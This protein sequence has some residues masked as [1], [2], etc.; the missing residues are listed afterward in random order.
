M[1]RTIRI[2]VVALLTIVGLIGASA[3][4]RADDRDEHRARC[5]QNIRQ[6]EDRL[7]DA[8]QRHGD[9]SK[10]AR[11]RRAQLEDQRRAC[12]DYRDMDHH[13]HHDMDHHDDP[14]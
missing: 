8:V 11:K 10:Q 7:R 5:E 2:F 1:T 9:D 6:A 3:P 14:H 4:L 13:E 12:P